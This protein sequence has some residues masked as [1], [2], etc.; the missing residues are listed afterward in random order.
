MASGEPETR[1]LSQKC[2]FVHC[3]HV[4]AWCRS[5]QQLPGDVYPDAAKLLIEPRK[6]LLVF[7]FLNKEPFK[8][9]ASAAAY[10]L[11]PG[12]PL[13]PVKQAH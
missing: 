1:F 13:T 3:V 8:V 7:F 11:P 6:V 10:P 2:I 4:V 12:A 9:G 5:L